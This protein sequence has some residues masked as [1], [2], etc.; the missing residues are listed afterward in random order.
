MRPRARRASP[1]PDPPADERHQPHALDLIHHRRSR[2]ARTFVAAPPPPR[3]AV[4]V[5]AAEDKDVRIGKGR[6]VK[7]DPKKYAARDDW[8]TGGGRR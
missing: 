5:R 1:A 4:V 7:D 2:S 6:W 8:F 3:A